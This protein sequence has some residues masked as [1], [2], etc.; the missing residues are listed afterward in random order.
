MNME[1][2]EI[3][4]EGAN[5]NRSLLALTNCIN[6]LSEDKKRSTTFIP[7]RNS[8]LTRILKDSLGGTTPIVMI[9]CISPNSVYLDE[10]LNS[11]KYAEIA[12]QVKVDP[13]EPR[14]WAKYT[15]YN[16]SN[17]Q[18]KIDKLEKECKFLRSALR[19]R[20]NESWN[21]SGG[22]SGIVGGRR[23]KEGGV[24]VVVG[25]G[26]KRGKRGLGGGTGAGGGARGTSEASGSYINLCRLKSTTSGLCTEEEFSQL[27]QTLC[28]NIEDLNTMRQNVMEIDE[29]IVQNDAEINEIQGEIDTLEKDLALDIKE[30]EEEVQSNPRLERLYKELSIAADCLEENLDLKENLIKDL[31]VVGRM[32]D[33]VKRVLNKMFSDRLSCSSAFKSSEKDKEREKEVLRL[34]GELRRKDEVIGRLRGELKLT[35]D[36]GSGSSSQKTLIK[37]NQENGFL[38]KK[39]KLKRSEE[40]GELSGAPG[41][42]S[43]T[44]STSM[45]TKVKAMEQNFKI[46]LN[47]QNFLQ[48]MAMKKK[49][50]IARIYN[51]EKLP[52]AQN[53]RGKPIKEKLA[54]K[55]AEANFEP[56]EPNFGG[57]GHQGRGVGH[58]ECRSTESGGLSQPGAPNDKKKRYSSKSTNDE[59]RQGGSYSDVHTT[60]TDSLERGQELGGVHARLLEAKNRKLPKSENDSNQLERRRMRKNFVK[61]KSDQTLGRSPT[62][63]HTQKEEELVKNP[64]HSQNQNPAKD[65]KETKKSML[66]S[67]SSSL[68]NRAKALLQ[69]LRR[70][71]NHLIRDLSEKDNFLE[72]SL[73]VQNL[74]KNMLIDYNPESQIRSDRVEKENSLPNA[75]ESSNP[76]NRGFGDDQAEAPKNASE[77]YFA[78]KERVRLRLNAIRDSASYCMVD[79]SQTNPMSIMSSDRGLTENGLFKESIGDD[80]MFKGI[81]ID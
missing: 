70:E 18:K 22:G 43:E 45:R 2:K 61:N 54:A 5:I 50:S 51:N 20:M 75:E 1:G 81:E 74:V 55:R 14:Q 53:K 8:K 60:E 9:V 36:P 39:G 72:K 17:Y 27:V 56:Q 69:N 79:D 10:T 44:A 49:S 40:E 37:E 78:K 64:K 48:K 68:N 25:G 35:V 24:E 28:D 12:K 62:P 34:K 63:T 67:Q 32:I 42:R 73:R 23:P 65:T 13:N 31:N 57:R 46:N 47:K 33:C 30:D 15:I 11:I 66:K 3:L 38:E 77:H 59:K 80:K 21:F 71:T 16:E 29:L 52:N 6:I 26:R 19:G 58:T 76:K 7:Y 41:S 4:Q